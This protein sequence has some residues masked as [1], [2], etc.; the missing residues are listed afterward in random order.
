[1]ALA[2]VLDSRQQWDA[3]VDRKEMHDWL[4]SLKQPDGSFVMHQDGE[5]DVRASYCALSVAAL[6]GILTPELAKGAAEF[7]AKCVFIV[8][9]NVTK[10]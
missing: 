9:G 5:V 3:I 2:T 10:I 6:L 1:M 8:D 7:I 4:L